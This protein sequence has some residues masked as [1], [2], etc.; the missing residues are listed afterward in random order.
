MS[1]IEK[2]SNIMIRLFITI[3]YKSYKF[4]DYEQMHAKI[5]IK[6]VK[7]TVNVCV[8]NK[9]LTIDRDIFV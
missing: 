3:I 1:Q 5:L 8:F 4:V 9:Q 7:S 2:L 6:L